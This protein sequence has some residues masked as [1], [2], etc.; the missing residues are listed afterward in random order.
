MKNIS[1]EKIELEKAIKK[2]EEADSVGD[3]KK[4]LSAEMR[5]R[6]T[7]IIGYGTLQSNDMDIVDKFRERY[8][9]IKYKF[10]KVLI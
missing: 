3:E 4:F 6:I 9:A 10:G 2:M 5:Y 1:K 7:Q 8:L